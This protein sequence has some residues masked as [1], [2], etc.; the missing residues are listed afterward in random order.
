[1]SRRA[2]PFVA[3]VLLSVFVLFTPASGVPTAP[4]GTDK[5]VHLALF[6]LLATTGRHARIPTWPLAAGLAGY[7]VL[8]EVLQEALPL[9]RSATVGDVLADLGG[10]A[11]GLAVVSLARARRARAGRTGRAGA[12]LDQTRP[13]P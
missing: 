12:D 11:A 2:L 1:M 13:T 6:T 9:G 8:S 3:S 7:A 10:A 4:P 5:V